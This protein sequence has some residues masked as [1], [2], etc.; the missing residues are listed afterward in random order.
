MGER[1]LDV[2]LAFAD[3]AAVDDKKIYFKTVPHGKGFAFT[4]WYSCECVG[5]G[6]RRLVVQLGQLHTIL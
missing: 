3:G 5:R 1:D 6:S 4:Q 2:E